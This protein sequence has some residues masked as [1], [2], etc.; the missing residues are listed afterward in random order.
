MIGEL[1]QAA[2]ES[3]LVDAERSRRTAGINP[4]FVAGIKGMTALDRFEYEILRFNEVERLLD[5]SIPMALFLDNCAG[6]LRIRGLPQADVFARVANEVGNTS[7]GVRPSQLG[8]A[9][10]EVTHPEAIIGRDEMLDFVFLS[11]GARVGRSVGRMT[12][13]RFEAGIQRKL[14]SGEPWLMQGTAWVIADHYV[15]TNH[16][17]VDARKADEPH[18]AE[19]DFVKQG[20]SAELEFDFDGPGCAIQRTAVEE[21]VAWDLDLDYALLKVPTL[22]RP[23]LACAQA[24][25]RFGPVSWLPV[26]IIQHPRGGYKKIGIRSN[27][28]TG[29]T[30]R[31]LRYFTDTDIGSSGA[32]VCD[33]KWQVIALHRGS[34]Q[35]KNVN[36]RGNDSAYVTFGSQ[37]SAVMSDLAVKKPELAPLWS[38]N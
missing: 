10:M 5:G 34:Y 6:Y 35:A 17:V 19:A 15:L 29:A 37:I 24:A 36:Y 22:S 12:V 31:E 14:A 2:V 28:V 21:L 11:D 9:P 20:R 27:L 8:G 3:G 13:P 25:V 1:V 7:S 30:D 23:K 16:H 4:G 38:G 32:P 26:N 18:A 33:D